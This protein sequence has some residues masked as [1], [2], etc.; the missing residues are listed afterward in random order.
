MHTD[1]EQKHKR[2]CMFSIITVCLNNL[3]GLEHT[4]A[5]IK[6]QLCSDFEWIVVDGD[7]KDGTV[8][9]LNELSGQNMR[10]ISDPDHGLCDA[11]DK[12]LFMCI[13]GFLR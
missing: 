2:R 4:S 11:M 5:S 10:Y 12:G 13:P 8:G 6:E 1:N 9:F 7:S 3:S